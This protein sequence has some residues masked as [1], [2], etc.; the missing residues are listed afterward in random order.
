MTIY[1]LRYRLA[2]ALVR[3][4]SWAISTKRPNGMVLW[5]LARHILR[6]C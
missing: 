4:A 6:T 3:L 1:G 2:R 5:K